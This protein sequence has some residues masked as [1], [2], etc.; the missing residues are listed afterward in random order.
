MIRKALLKDIDDAFKVILDA[1]KE[2]ARIGSSQWQDLDGYPNK[3]T[4]LNDLKNE[5][6]FVV[7]DEEKII[8]VTV[9]CFGEDPTY[10]KIY[11][12]DWLLN[13]SN[14]MTIPLENWERR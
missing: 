2:F 13:T 10:K 6:L 8:G 7:E 9:F 1:K 14:Y 4:L 11:E 5:G 3:E 12:G